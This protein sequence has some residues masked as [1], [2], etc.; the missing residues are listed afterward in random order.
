MKNNSRNLHN[1]RG[2][3]MIELMLA[4]LIGIL[5]MGVAVY[6]FTKQEKSLRT[7]NSSTN[8]RAK[9]RHAIKILAQELKEIGFGLPSGEGFVAPD[10]VANSSTLSYRANMFDVRAS[11]PP[12][13]ASGG[14]IGDT[15]IDVVDSGTTFS[16]G[17]K[18]IIYNPSYE[19]SEL[20]TVS[21]TP[22]ATSIPLGSG[23]ANNYSYG[24]NSKLVTINKYNDVVVDLSGTTIRKTIDGGTP[25][26]LAGDV[27]ALA[28][29]FYGVTSTTLVR[30]I[31]IT[32]TMQDSSD[33]SI[34]QDF[35]TDITLRN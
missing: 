32:I 31:G 16:D 33:A 21:G 13:A 26:P 8:I 6:V 14:S 29:D 24:V 19:D 20:N 10:P 30:T 28:F 35:S 34:T 25:V 7:E 18:I 12:S 11:T 2:F 15:D 23:L 5:I 17:D 1:E 4:A 22:S 27:S 3:T 9:G